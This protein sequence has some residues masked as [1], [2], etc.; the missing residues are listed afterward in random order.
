MLPRGSRARVASTEPAAPAIR[1]TRRRQGPRGTSNANARNSNNSP[2]TSPPWQGGEN[3][4]NVAES[5][6]HVWTGLVDLP[7]YSSRYIPPDSCFLRPCTGLEISDLREGHSRECPVVVEHESELGSRTFSQTHEDS[8]SSYETRRSVRQ[9][10]T[11][12]S[13]RAESSRA[14]P[15]R[16]RSRRAESQQ[17]CIDA[18]SRDSSQPLNSPRISHPSVDASSTESILRRADAAA[19][20]ARA[21][22]RLPSL[23]F[24]RSPISGL[25]GIFLT[26]LFRRARELRLMSQGNPPASDFAVENLDTMSPEDA[27]AGDICAIC[28]VPGCSP[29][30][31]FHWCGVPVSSLTKTGS[32]RRCRRTSWSSPPGRWGGRCRA[33]TAS[34]SPASSL[35][36]SRCLPPSV[37]AIMS[38]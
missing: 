16:N 5:S 29:L 38:P 12:R 9:R 33:S 36:S 7:S 35:G 11:N 20:A 31:L 10:T 18:G 14:A 21:Q 27:S 30:S 28:Q 4:G 34:M 22:D 24:G 17:G 26:Q 1:G 8:L 19:A 13:E 2:D 6:R 32:S 37:L 25:P 15:A 23:A 3:Y